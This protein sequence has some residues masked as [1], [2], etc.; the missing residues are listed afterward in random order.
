VV[1]RACAGRRQGGAGA[2]EE[3]PGHGVGRVPPGRRGA[4][5]GRALERGGVARREPPG[6]AR[7]RGLVV[8]REGEGEGDERGEGA[9]LGIQNPAIT[10]TKSPRA[11]GGRE[12]WKRGRGSCCMGK[13]NERKG[14]RGGA[15]MGGGGGAQGGAPGRARLG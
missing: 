10:V 14:E 9:H 2:T 13:S 4:A 8:R 6:H 5:A 12:R 11:R 3:A 7:G 1:R 15:R